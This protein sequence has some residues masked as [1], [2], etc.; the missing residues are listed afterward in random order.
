M[1]GG[2]SSFDLEAAKRIAREFAKV[3]A[4]SA[5]PRVP[6]LG[7]PLP[8]TKERLAYDMEHAVKSDCRTAYQGLGPLAIAAFLVDAVRENGCQW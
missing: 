8:G 7:I 6:S 5:N 3:D 1:S 2:K 4:Q